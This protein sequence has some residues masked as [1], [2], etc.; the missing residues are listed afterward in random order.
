[1]N[2]PRSL[3]QRLDAQLGPLATRAAAT[4]LACDRLA[5]AVLGLVG[6]VGVLLLALPAVLPRLHA[7]LWLLPAALLLRALAAAVA[8][9]QARHQPALPA[10]DPALGVVLD[11]AADLALYLPLALYPGV[12]ATPVVL[13]VVLGLLTDIAGLAPLLRGGERRRDGPMGTSDRA[14]VFGLIGLILAV[15]PRTAPWLPWLLLPAAGLALA[16]VVQRVRPTP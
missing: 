3:K 5:W 1:M 9:I 13:L 14:L 4:G 7:V 6:V 15:D 8:D 11:A 16:T 12:A 10:A 2:I